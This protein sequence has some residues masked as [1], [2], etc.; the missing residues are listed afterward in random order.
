MLPELDKEFSLQPL[1]ISLQLSWLWL[2]KRQSSTLAAW[3]ECNKSVIPLLEEL[4]R[5]EKFYNGRLKIML[6]PRPVLLVEP[7][8]IAIRPGGFLITNTKPSFLDFLWS[9]WLDQLCTLLL[10]DN[11][12]MP[13]QIR[14]YLS[15][16]YCMPKQILKVSCKIRD[17]SS[18]LVVTSPELR[19]K[20]TMSFFFLFLFTKSLKNF[21]FLSQP[22]R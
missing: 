4:T 9:N 7:W 21:V 12:P 16:V 11:L 6:Y 1:P 5:V 2:Y 18:Q 13:K 8:T 19:Y 3:G 20:A 10:W 15:S 17:I 14:I 22:L